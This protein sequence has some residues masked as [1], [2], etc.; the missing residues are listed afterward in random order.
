[1][2]C[3][4]KMLEPGCTKLRCCTSPATELLLLLSGDRQTCAGMPE[5][6]R[7]AIMHK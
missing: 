3:I 5:P 1:M 7:L 4:T 6:G 2:N